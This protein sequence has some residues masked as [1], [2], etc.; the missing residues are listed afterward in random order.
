MDA[1]WRDHYRGG[2]RTIAD[3]AFSPFVAR[4]LRL[5]AKAPLPR[6]KDVPAHLF[7]L[8][9]ELK[10]IAPETSEALAEMARNWP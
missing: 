6:Y 3:R 2:L 5:V 1:A 9:D 7:E 8:A 4:A 10:G